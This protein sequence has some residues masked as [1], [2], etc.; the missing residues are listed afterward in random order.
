MIILSWNIH[1]EHNILTGVMDITHQTD[2][3]IRDKGISTTWFSSSL[4][5]WGHWYSPNSVLVDTTFQAQVWLFYLFI[6]F[7]D[8]PGSL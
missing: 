7:E 6:G 5:N 3:N 8:I 1:F 4:L 2:F